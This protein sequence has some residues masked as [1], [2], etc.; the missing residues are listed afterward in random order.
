MC[1]WDIVPNVEINFATCA[2]TNV[3]TL[4]SQ[5][6][7]RGQRHSNMNMFW[8]FLTEKKNKVVAFK[9]TLLSQ[10]AV[11]AG[12]ASRYNKCHTGYY[13]GLLAAW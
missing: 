8:C 12:A 6:L 10:P 4:E 3:T 2:Q 9:C 5:T 1:I 7:E 11:T 13:I